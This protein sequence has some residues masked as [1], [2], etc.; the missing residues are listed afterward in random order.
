MSRYGNPRRAGSMH[1]SFT[2]ARVH[3]RRR[4][5]TTINKT[6]IDGHFMGL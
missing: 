5:I 4:T 1:P 3:C 2:R 6:P